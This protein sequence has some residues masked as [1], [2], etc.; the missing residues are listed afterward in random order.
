MAKNPKMPKEVKAMLASA[1]E[2]GFTWRYTKGCHVQVRTAE[3]RVIASSGGTPSDARSI[4]NFRGQMRRGG[5][6]LE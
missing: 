4:L 5:V 6:T 3:G 1:V 2:Q